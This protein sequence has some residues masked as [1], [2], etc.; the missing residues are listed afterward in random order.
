M[1][2]T[3]APRQ[4]LANN[5]LAPSRLALLLLLLVSGMAL[6]ACRLSTAETADL[7][8]GEGVLFAD[9]FSGQ[10]DCG[11]VLYNRGGAVAAV[12]DGVM[13]L[14][15]SQVGS[16]WWTN[17][18]RSFDDVVITVDTEQISGPDNN[19]YG[20]ICRYQDPENFYLFLIS[21]DGYYAIGK[22]QSGSEQV[23]YLT[24]NNEYQPSEAINQGAA[25]NRLEVR[26]VGNELSLTI[27]GMPQPAVT[28]PTFVVGDV[29][30]GVSTLEA[31]TA[32]VEFDNFR[33]TAP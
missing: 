16:L 6:V 13:Q 10:E 12:T 14:T 11:W 9:D 33:V 1:N 20:I 29:G 3:A 22:Y 24:P 28:D 26:C 7:C 15:T 2:E 32:V 17:P 30:L 23:L 31:G 18:N 4:K 25:S 5:Q 8:T 27:N 19:A 21:G